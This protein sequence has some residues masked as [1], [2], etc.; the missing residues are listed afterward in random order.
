MVYCNLLCTVDQVSSKGV[1]KHQT[2]LCCAHT[3]VDRRLIH[4]RDA[5]K[6]YIEKVSALRIKAMPTQNPPDPLCRMLSGNPGR[7]SANR[8][9]VP[10]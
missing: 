7:L 9:I 5:E 2:L 6:S 3:F 8:S 1:T 4:G 10:A